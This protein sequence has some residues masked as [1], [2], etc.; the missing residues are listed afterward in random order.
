MHLLS[1]RFHLNLFKL[2]EKSQAEKVLCL[3]TENYESLWQEY[4]K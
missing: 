4:N 3:T 2:A 1:L